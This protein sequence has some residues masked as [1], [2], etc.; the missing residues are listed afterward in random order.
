MTRRRCGDAA[1]QL[2]ASDLVRFGRTYRHWRNSLVPA[3][4]ADKRCERQLL[5]LANPQ[6][7]DDLATD[8]GVRE[9]AVGTVVSATPLVVDVASRRIGEGSRIVL[10][11]RGETACVE[12]PTVGL[13]AQKGSFKFSGLAIGPLTAVADGTPRRFAWAPATVPSVEVGERL[14]VADFA[15]F[16]GLTKNTHLAVDR[17]GQDSTSAPRPDCTDQSYAEDPDAHRWC[18]RPHEYAEAAWSDELADRRARGELNPQAWPP[19]VD[20]DAFEVSP[21]GAPVGG[22][23]RRNATDRSPDDVTID[24]LE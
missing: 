23:H 15:W 24:D 5:T 6:A 4:E 14:L 11:H 20:G 1:L 8:A 9:L 22:R 12:S 3:L 10:L 16:C 2:H 18:C 21:A 13:T 17:P 19:V 7:A